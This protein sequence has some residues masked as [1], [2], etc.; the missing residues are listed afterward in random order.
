[1]RGDWHFIIV[2]CF[3]ILA[4]FH[5]HMLATIL[6]RPVVNH[7]AKQNVRV[8]FMENI[9]PCFGEKLLPHPIHVVWVPSKPSR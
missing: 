5:L 3:D 1:M 8:P 7:Y 4:L 9:F 2:M 6:K